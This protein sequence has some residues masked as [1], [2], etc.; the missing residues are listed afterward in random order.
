MQPCHQQL[1]IQTYHIWGWLASIKLWMR[2]RCSLVLTHWDQ[3][4]T[5]APETAWNMQMSMND[6][7]MN[8]QQSTSLAMKLHSFTSQFPYFLETLCILRNPCIHLYC[9][10]I[11]VQMQSKRDGLAG[12]HI[13]THAHTHTHTHT[14]TAKIAYP[15]LS[16]LDCCLRLSQHG[17]NVSVFLH[18]K[19]T[20]TYCQCPQSKLETTQQQMEQTGY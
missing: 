10:P 16:V 14:H 20:V 12:L 13:H 18:C 11:F 6:N 4:Y 5:L 9:Q 3:P 8:T 2:K 17:V 15:L 1:W 7:F 19:L